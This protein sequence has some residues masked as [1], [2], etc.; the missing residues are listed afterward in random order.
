MRAQ[1]LATEAV[2]IYS[3]YAINCIC[4]YVFIAGEGGVAVS[5]PV[6]QAIVGPG[7]LAVARPVGTAV[8]GVE[9]EG[10]NQLKTSNKKKP[11]QGL[12]WNS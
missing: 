12:W 8:A 11:K 10:I 2:F 1:P 3:W 4:N 9:V 6:A 5:K 7:G